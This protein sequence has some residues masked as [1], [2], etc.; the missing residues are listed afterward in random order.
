MTSTVSYSSDSWALCFHKRYKQDVTY[1][2]LK[3]FKTRFE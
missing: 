1:F 2:S 3:S